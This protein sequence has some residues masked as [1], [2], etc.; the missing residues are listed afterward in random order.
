MAHADRSVGKLLLPG[1]LA[2]ALA[3][4]AGCRH[5][6]GGGESPGSKAA[7]ARSEQGKTSGL[8]IVQPEKR[9]IRMT[10]VQPGTLQA[11]EETPIY[12]RIAGYIEK[13]NFN[14]GD[15]VKKGDVLVNMWIPDY[16]EAHAQKKAAA[17]RA[18]VQIKVAEAAER[19]AEAKL[20]TAKARVLSAQAGVKRAQASYTRW[21]SEYKRLQ[22]LVGQRVLDV[23]VRDETYR[24]FE[25]AVAALEQANAMVSESTSARDQ[26]AADLLRAQVDVESARVDLIVAQTEEKQAKVTVDYGEIKAP[27][28]GVITQRNIS[29]GDYLEPGGGVSNRPLFLLEQ[30][31]PVRVF[32]GVPELA[33]FFVHDQDTALIRFQ[34]IPGATREGKIVRSGFSANPAT[35]TVQTEIDIPNAD[36]H[37]HPGWYVTVTITVNRKQIWTLP[38]NA[39]SSQGPQNY[40]VYLQIDGKPVR[41]QVLIGASDDTHVEILKKYVPNTNTNDW[42]TMDGTERVYAGNLDTLAA[43][44]PV[45]AASPKQ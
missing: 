8:Q 17:R 40:Y 22:V 6:G 31:D 28:A 21:D 11:Y 13:Y 30:I 24:Q 38:P 9:D 26:A 19:A 14:I 10:V 43:G 39:I 12:S 27:Y 42:P 35:R 44:Q 41:N 18:E 15:R 32:V 16:V 33:S 1:L 45:P 20:E 23:Q 36:L 5:S 25:E 2:V 37:L 29:P 3:L 34:A 7:D 4:A